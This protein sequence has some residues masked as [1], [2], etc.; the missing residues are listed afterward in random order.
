MQGCTPAR[1]RQIPGVRGQSP[2][3]N[4]GDTIAEQLRG[5]FP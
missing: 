5:H 2:R 1:M 4:R 3:L